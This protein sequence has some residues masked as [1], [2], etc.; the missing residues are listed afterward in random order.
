MIIRGDENNTVSKLKI[1]RKVITISLLL[2][3]ILSMY[4]N[5]GSAEEKKDEDVYQNPSHEDETQELMRLRNEGVAH[6][7]SGIALKKSIKVFEDAL[8]L[9]SDGQIENYNMGVAFRSQNEIDKAIEYFQKALDISDDFANPHYSL[10]LIY[11]EQNNI[12]EALNA[13]A[14]SCEIMP[15]E[16]SCHY[17]LSRIYR[18]LGDE[19]Q[20]LQYIINTLNLDSYHTGAI[21]QLYLYHQNNGDQEKAKILFKE[22]SRLKKAFGKTRLEINADESILSKPIDSRVESHS[23]LNMPTQ[24]EPNFNIKAL[25][26]DKVIKSIEVTDFNRDGYD[27]FIAATNQGELLF[28]A[29]NQ[30]DT[31]DLSKSFEIDGSPE[32]IDIAASRLKQDGSTEVVIATSKGV[33]MSQT[34]ALVDQ[35]L[36]S[37]SKKEKKKKK[38]TERVPFSD[39]ELDKK[40]VQLNSDLAQKVHLIDIDHD[41]DL[42]IILDTFKKVYINDGN[43]GFTENTTFL[44]SSDAEMISKYDPYFSGGDFRNLTMVD[45]VLIDQQGSRRIFRDEMAGRYSILDAEKLSP[46][47]GIEWSAAADMDNDGLIEIVN[48]TTNE[49]FI[50][51]NHGDHNFD[52]KNVGNTDVKHSNTSA[53]IADFNNDGY[54]DIFVTD[55]E[56]NINVWSKIESGYSLLQHKPLDIDEPINSEIK[57]IDFNNNGFLD[58]LALNESGGV[59]LL[60]NQ[61]KNE[62]NWIK[63]NLN[64]LR[65]PPDGQYVQAEVRYGDFYSKY[66]ATD[67]NLH[68]P[69]GIASHAEILRLTWPNGFV[70]NK[71]KIDANSQYSFDESERISGSCPSIYAWGDDG[72][73]Y[74]T[75]AFISGPMGVPIAKDNYFPIDNDEY[76]KIPAEKIKQDGDSYKISIVEELREVTY[77]DQIRLF[78]VDRPVTTEIYPNEYLNPPDFPKFKLHVT[79]NSK[80]ILSANDHMG[81]DVLSLVS[82]LDYKYPHNFTRTQYT[83]FTTPHSIEFELPASQYS[84]DNLR[85]FLTGWFYY[86]DSTSLISASQ[87][88]DIQMRMPEL[89]AYVDGSWQSLKTIGIPSGKDKTIVIELN[90]LVPDRTEKLRIV[91]NIEV[92][93][94][95]ILFDTGS[96]EINDIA[97]SE[98]PLKSATMM[99]HGFSRLLDKPGDFPEPDRFDYNDVSYQSMWNPLSG[100][101]TRYGEVN[102][103]I[104]IEDSRMAVLGSGDKISLEFD[105]KLLPKQKPGWKRDI[106]LY[107]NGYVKDGDKYTVHAGD[108]N[109]MPFAGMESYPYSAKDKINNPF[110]T[111]SYQKY[112]EEFQ[113]RK[114][115]RFT[116]YSAKANP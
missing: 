78:A 66:E 22:F 95:R 82:E 47:T 70:E 17:Q 65:S 62:N 10:G 77:L 114:P 103:L 49:L 37:D 44:S 83:G 46:I 74:I 73:T 91:S 80:N 86:F 5:V 21:Y 88:K 93:W 9:N 76:I 16:P 3:P 81:N 7:E 35:E 115:L 87:N 20:T 111:N 71:F 19:K 116:N 64:G 61:I 45:F 101:Y 14:R 31:F 85:L 11:R 68:I 24:F 6:F 99:F 8:A 110:K 59:Y 43:A 90:D 97:M 23:I 42:E 58:I 1:K 75:D 96:A 67:S 102:T 53:L 30:S 92:Y 51:Y 38:K 32:I 84:A 63:L 55:E 33:F 34:K 50:D 112:I 60:D 57:L 29:N 13:F 72:Y 39:V 108:V 15:D 107:L 18:E 36:E 105:A 48:L 113:T 109:P 12:N 4:L 106:I 27:D 100:N 2:F 98:L 25:Q 26:I 89:Q 41:G 40:F 54:K 94:D 56:K 28:Y 79:E 104:N 69:L 52:I